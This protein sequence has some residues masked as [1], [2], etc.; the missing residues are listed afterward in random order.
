VI[1]VGTFI[2]HLQLAEHMASAG[3][4]LPDVAHQYVS[5]LDWLVCQ[6]GFLL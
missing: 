5:Q 6:P 3:T 1:A 4:L 2:V